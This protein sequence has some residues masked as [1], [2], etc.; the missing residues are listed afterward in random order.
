MSM[1]IGRLNR[2]PGMRVNRK[3]HAAA[4]AVILSA[5]AGGRVAAAPADAKRP[6]V[7]LCMT[8]D[9][10]WGDTGYNGLT[11]IKTPSLDAMAAAGMRFDR[12]YAAA[13]LCSPTRASVLSGR[14]PFRSGVFNPGSP[15]RTEELSLAEA[16]KPAG[17]A[18]GH[19]GKWHLNG[20]SGPGKPV[21]GDDPLNPGRFGFDAWFSVSNYF[22]CDW[23]FSR[24]GTPEKVEGDGSDAIVDRALK[25]IED[26]AK[27][28]KPFLVLV[29]FG[30]PHTPHKPTAAD[31]QS[32][33]GDP[34]Y[35][36]L[37]GVDRAM[38]AL[39]AGLRRLGVAD[40][41]ML[42][43]CSDNGAAGQGSNG[44]FRGGKG[45]VWEGGV[46]VPGLLEWPARVT[47]GQTAVRA[48]TSDLHP[49]ILE[50]AGVT[51]PKPVLP[52]D[53]ISLLPLLDG[54]MTERPRPIG[55][56][57]GGGKNMDRETGHAAWTGNRYKLHKIAGKKKAGVTCELYD[58]LEDPS[59]KKDL[60]AEKP[61]VVAAMKAE[62][63]AW[64]DSV[65]R[66]LRGDDYK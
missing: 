45:S 7:V 48:C 32:A 20:V 24:N 31:L 9:Q 36:E 53:G 50:A 15:F 33:G 34:Y 57:H 5:W 12:F 46:H 43:F 17:Y 28:G 25:W 27:G 61:D 64:Q 41:T 29:W 3:S 44:T 2:R 63:D 26:V 19:F 65:L 39:R 18:T 35:G 47:P 40:D 10:G 49:T 52:L 6:N 8:D 60:A 30:N 13:P 56:W 38:G 54:R 51:V 55:F 58:L 23:T 1:G 62:L 42:W 11:K 4:V 14:H 59:E 21:P 22:E 37:V 66:S 16:I